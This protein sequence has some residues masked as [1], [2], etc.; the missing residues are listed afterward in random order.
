MPVMSRS[1]RAFCCGAVWRSSSAA[2]ARELR[3]QRLGRDVL[4]IGAGSGSVAQ[5]L[6]SRNP[7]LALTAID[8]DPHMTRAIATRLHGFPN[9]KAKT[10]DATA[11]PF[12]DDSFDSVV[13]CLMLHHIVDWERAVAEVARVLRPGGTFVGYDL[14]HTPLASLFHRLDGSP[15]RLIVPGDFQ[16]ECERNGFTISVQSRLFGHVM[17]F[18]ARKNTEK[19]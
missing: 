14:V 5:Q 10:A 1:E 16:A 15:H 13:S 12:P 17:R 2:I 6:L 11:M 18:V 8:I 4:E 9:A 3:A 7:E 19:I